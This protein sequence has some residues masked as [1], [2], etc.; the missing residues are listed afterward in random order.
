MYLCDGKSVFSTISSVM[1][2]F[3]W[4]FFQ[5]SSIIFDVNVKV[6]SHS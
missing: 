4:K 1:F 2:F 3:L 5:D 6:I